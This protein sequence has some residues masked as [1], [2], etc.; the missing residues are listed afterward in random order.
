MR[1]NGGD[2]VCL[3]RCTA[4]TDCLFGNATCAVLP[5]SMGQRV[6]TVAL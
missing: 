5:E 2:L 3:P 1:L 6:C 4:T